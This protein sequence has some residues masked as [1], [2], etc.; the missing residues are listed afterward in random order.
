MA[1]WSP[2]D[3][4][5]L[6]IGGLRVTRSMRKSARRF[7]TT[8]DESFAEVLDGCADSRRPGGWIDA[9]IRRAYRALHDLGW[10]HSVEVWRE[11][12]LVGGL[13]GVAIGGLFAGESMF[14]RERDA[15]KVALMRLVD[16][17]DDGQAGRLVDVQWAT[18]HLTSL[19][20]V[21]ISRA[22]YLRRLQVALGTPL[23]AAWR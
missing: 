17:L 7:T 14:H 15:S 10:V 22:S 6:P 21:E 11:G 8:V 18:S 1:W 16:L 23:P 19:G 2:V 12:L 3:R 9:G 20:V 5:V 13:Y 4:A